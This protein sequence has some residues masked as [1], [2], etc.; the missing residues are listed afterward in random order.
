[1]AEATLNDVII[2][3]ANDNADQKKATEENTSV[4]SEVAK[5]FNK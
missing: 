4:L 5:S 2:Q 3:Q 1:M